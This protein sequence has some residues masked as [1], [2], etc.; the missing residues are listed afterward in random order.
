MSPTPRQCVSILT[1]VV[2]FAA[3]VCCTCAATAANSP[4][5]QDVRSTG[6][7]GARQHA[8]CSREASNHS[9]LGERDSHPDPKGSHCPHCARPE[10]ASVP[11]VQKVTAG[12]VDSLA[13]AVIPLWV[14]TIPAFREI[15]GT[16]WRAFPSLP[17]STLLSLHCAL[18]A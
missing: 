13:Q 7:G 14:V 6:H 18:T 17:L 9:G 10:L 2:V 11:P 12:N 3:S 1:A 5:G 16:P 4:A 15:R 8:C